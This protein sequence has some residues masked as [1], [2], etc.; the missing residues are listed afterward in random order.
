MI[1][2]IL[3][4][5]TKFVSSSVAEDE[6]FSHKG[7]E[8]AKVSGNGLCN[9]SQKQTDIKIT[10][11]FSKAIDSDQLEDGVLISSSDDEQFT[12]ILKTEPLPEPAI[13]SSDYPIQISSDEGTTDVQIS[14]APE[15]HYKKKKCK[16]RHKFHKSKKKFKT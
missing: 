12:K 8:P 11:N 2:E 9:V 4:S 6:H 14:G 1:H 3:T 7:E 5:Q 13:L 16:R 10:E 15:Y